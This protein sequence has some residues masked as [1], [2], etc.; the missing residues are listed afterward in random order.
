[1]QKINN[2]I[3]LKLHN[4]SSSLKHACNELETIAKQGRDENITL[5]VR[6]IAMET[7]QYIEELNSQQKTIFTSNLS[8]EICNSDISSHKIRSMNN[9]DDE[10]VIEECCST[11]VYIEQAYR[12]I[13]NENF[14]YSG[15]RDLLKYQLNGIKCAF[16]KLK[17]L[18]SLMHP[19]EPLRKV[20][21]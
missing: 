10:L 8:D 15:L 3:F 20:L 19:Q 6:S 9:V 11:E 12:S 17:L 7:K 18:K 2:I 4:L 1:M 21:F 5:S 14:Q 13:L 16:M